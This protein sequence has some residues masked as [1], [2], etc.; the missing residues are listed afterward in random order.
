LG[1]TLKAVLY[2][3]DDTVLKLTDP[4]NPTDYGQRTDDVLTILVSNVGY[5]DNMDITYVLGPPIGNSFEATVVI[6]GMTYNFSPRFLAGSFGEFTGA[7]SRSGLPGLTA[8]EGTAA[9]LAEHELINILTD[10]TT[11]TA[12]AGAYAFNETNKVFADKVGSASLLYSNPSIVNV[13]DSEPVAFEST[14]GTIYFTSYGNSNGKYL[15]GTFEAT[16]V[17]S[18]ETSADPASSE[19]VSLIGAISGRFGITL[20]TST[21]AAP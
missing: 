16:V 18:Q 6:N 7:I 4:I 20:G 21:E 12:S 11:I 8:G 2:R 15:S 17:G 1:S 9:T 19:V 14:S 13:D 3:A 10:P 5:S